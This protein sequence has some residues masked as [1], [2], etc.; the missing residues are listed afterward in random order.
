MSYTY[1]GLLSKA[2]GQIL[3]VAACIHVLVADFKNHENDL[4]FKP[5]SSTVPSEISDYAINAAENF[6]MTCCQHCSFLAGRGDLDKEIK[7]CSELG[8]GKFYF[9]K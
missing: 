8:E 5:V 6:V 2:K 3:R 4:D 9:N 1:T 7:C